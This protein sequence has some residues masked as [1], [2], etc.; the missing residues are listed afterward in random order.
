VTP[1]SPVLSEEFIPYE[2][3]YAKQQR[4]YTPLPVIKNAAGVVLSRWHL[5]DEE[6]KAVAEGADVFLSIHT[7]NNPLQPLRIEI[8]EC[9][10]S[11]L[12]IAEYMGLVP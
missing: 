8:G 5:T 11:I 2:T 10:R 9:D 12:E 1:I 3:V 6:R 7:F 4:E